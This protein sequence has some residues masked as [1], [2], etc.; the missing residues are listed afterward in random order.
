MSQTIIRPMRH[1]WWHTFVLLMLLAGG[2]SRPQSLAQSSASPRVVAVGDI[3]GDFDALRGI[4]RHAGIIDAGGRWIAG[5]STLVQL[6]DFTDRGRNVRAVMDFF[7]DLEGQAT[8]AG[9]RVAVLLGNHEAMNLLG[10]GQ[11]V[12]TAIYGTFADEQSEQRRQTGYDAYIKFCITRSAELGRIVPGVSQPVLS[13]DAWMAAH[14]AGFLEYREAFGPQGRYGRWL[15]SK[16]AVLQVGDTVF[17]HAGVNPQRAP[18]RLED[19]NKQ[20]LA[21]IKRFDDFR[22]RMLDRKLILPF[23]TL[24]EMLAAAQVEVAAAAAAFNTRPADA[25]GPSVAVD[26]LTDRDPLG[27]TRLL[28][29]GRWSVLDPDGPLWFRGF[30][31]WPPDEGAIQIKPLLQRYHVAHFV[32]GHTITA[33]RRITPRFS[34]AVILIDT[35]MLSSYVPG[36]TASALE[37]QDGRFTAIYPS[38]RLTL[39]ESRVRA[40]EKR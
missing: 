18:G 27:L 36:G 4:L 17:L 26:P 23:F 15:R 12:T 38:E 31:M 30:A 14:P 16:P 11:D 20:V 3:H 24:S 37:I 8:A 35:G 39:L 21:E 28:D 2:V 6:G 1:A 32:V 40:P 5:N 13:K 33:T 10:E 19:I 9:G 25:F 29:I 34:A 22:S 7:V